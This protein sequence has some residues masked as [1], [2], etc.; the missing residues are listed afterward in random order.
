M[1]IRTKLMIPAGLQLLAMVPVV[2]VVA[3]SVTQT[4]QRLDLIGKAGSDQEQ[5][6]ELAQRCAEYYRDPA[7][8]DATAVR[9]RLDRLRTSMDSSAK[10]TL[11]RMAGILDAVVVRKTRNLEIEKEV[12]RLTT[13]SLEQ[14]NAYI[15][16]TVE[17]LLSPTDAAA[18]TD[19][20]KRVIVGAN[21]NTSSCLAV[22][23]LFYRMVSDPRMEK[24]L[25][26]YLAQAI[27][28]AENDVARLAGTPFAELPVKAQAANKAVDELV[29]EFITNR[30]AI[31]RATEESDSA[32]ES[33]VATIRGQADA[34]RERAYAS[35]RNAFLAVGGI[36]LLAGAV[37]LTVNLAY[38]QQIAR[39]VRSASGVFREIAQGEGDLTRRLAVTTQDEIGELARYFNRFMDKLQG[40][41]RDIAG[42]TSTLAGL[43]TELSSTAAQLASGAEETTAQSST[44]AAAA[45]EMATNMS[46]M[47]ASTEQMSANVKTVASAVEEMTASITEVARNAEQAAAVADSASRLAAE[48][49]E[50]I[51]QLDAAAAEIGK[52]IEVIQDIAEQTNLLALNATIEA[53]RAGDAGKGFAVVATEVKELA[54]QTAGATEDIRRRI[55]AIQGSTAETVRSMGEITK[56]IGTVNDVSRTIASAVEEQS[57]T[58]KEI[59]Q[60]VAQ[61]ASAAELV[62]QGVSQT[63]SASG[64]ITRNIAGVDTAAK[65]TAQGAAQTRTAGQEMSKLAEQLQAVVGQFKV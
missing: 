18:V 60:N 26:D 48:S 54:K 45:E 16:K 32:A 61:T 25:L 9:T 5:T 28:N 33:L 1:R 35:I 62:S 19:L 13:L 40:M 29:R 7:A 12:M 55:E 39:S 8:V 58:T 20:E 46:G 42:N 44:V 2:A 21:V 65:Q 17:R 30:T 50:K 24:D 59:A 3:W 10:A 41:I 52:V 6:R 63:A 15:E 31:A 47:A 4:R 64:E 36:A 14:S 38:G 56:V 51:G 49:G 37:V 22:Q 11:V 23:R 43:S 27:R 57:I 34:T 53:A